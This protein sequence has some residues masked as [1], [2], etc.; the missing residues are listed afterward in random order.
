[1]DL[2]RAAWADRCLLAVCPEEPADDAEA[3]SV[4]AHSADEIEHTAAAA[5][6]QLL[7]IQRGWEGSCVVVWALVDL[8]SA[9]FTS[10]PLVLGQIEHRARWSWKGLRR[11]VASWWLVAGGQRDQNGMS[12]RNSNP[13]SRISNSFHTT[14]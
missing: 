5:A 8:G 6:G 12:N 13:K 4:P 7:A 3:E 2:A 9:K 14:H 10:Q 11:L 1:M